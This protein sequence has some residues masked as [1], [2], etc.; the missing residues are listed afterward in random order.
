MFGRGFLFEAQRHYKQGGM[1]WCYAG[2]DE[3]GNRWPVQAAL[4]LRHGMYNYVQWWSGARGAPLA[5]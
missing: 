5:G 1:C 4:E 2:N 3:D